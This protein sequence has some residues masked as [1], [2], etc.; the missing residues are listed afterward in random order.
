MYNYLY[1]IIVS[2]LKTAQWKNRPT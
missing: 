1:S 2:Y